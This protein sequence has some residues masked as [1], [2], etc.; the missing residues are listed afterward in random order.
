MTG[1]D[2]YAHAEGLLE[3]AADDDLGSAIEHYR[4]AKARVH[5]T[6]ALAAAFACARL[7]EMPIRDSDAWQATAGTQTEV[8]GNPGEGLAPP[9]HAGPPAPAPQPP[10]ASAVPG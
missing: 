5:A 2:H 1:P 4:I 10:Q 9:P 7:G 6:L 3:K 8:A